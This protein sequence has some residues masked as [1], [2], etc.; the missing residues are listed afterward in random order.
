[1]SFKS[2]KRQVVSMTNVMYIEVCPLDFSILDE[3]VI[4]R[5]NKNMIA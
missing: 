2:H 5:F 3:G 1:M 4:V